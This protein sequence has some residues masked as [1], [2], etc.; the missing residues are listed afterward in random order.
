MHIYIEVYTYIDITICIY[1]YIQLQ[2]VWHRGEPSKLFSADPDGSHRIPSPPD[3][4][5]NEIP[6]G[7]KVFPNLNQFCISLYQFYVSYIY[8][9]IHIHVYTFL[10]HYI[11]II[12]CHTNFFKPNVHRQAKS[13]TTWQ[14]GK[15]N[16]PK[17]RH[18]PSRPSFQGS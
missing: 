2:M 7:P 13:Q 6:I 1:I 17:V 12:P 4:V 14:L 10:L 5:P 16:L 18:E 9:Y 15:S 11:P 8:I 3:F